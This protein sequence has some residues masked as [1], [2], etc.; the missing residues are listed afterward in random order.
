MRSMK[1]RYEGNQEGEAPPH[2]KKRLEVQRQ[3]RE[4]FTALRTAV[5]NVTDMANK[6][7]HP[8]ARLQ[9]FA[10][11]ILANATTLVAE[12][13]EDVIQAIDDAASM[14]SS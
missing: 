11:L 7:T 5:D 10:T 4:R 3:R 12:Q 2:V 1:E 14:A 13:L 8:D 9:V 6:T